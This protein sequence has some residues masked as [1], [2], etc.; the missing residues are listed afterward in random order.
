VSSGQVAQS[1]GSLIKR[2]NEW[3][4]AFFENGAIPAVLLTS[5][6]AV[7]LAE[8]ERI[9]G[10]W[11]KVLQGV[12]R[13][14]GTIVME[15]GL[16]PTV[17]GQNVVDLAMPELEKA[18]KEQILAAYDLPPG[19]AEPRMGLSDRRSLMESLWVNHLIPSTETWIEPVFNKQL[20]NALGLRLSFRYK[21]LEVMQRTELEKSES[22]VFLVQVIKG[23]FEDG[24]ASW[25]EY[26]SWVE[27]LGAWSNMP[28]LD[29]N[30]QYEE[31]ETPPQLQP[32]TGQEPPDEDDEGTDEN[33]PATAEERI[34]SR[35]PKA[36]GSERPKV[37]APPRWG[38]YRIGPT[39]SSQS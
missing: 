34:E 30:F 21:E 1:P 19:M 14:F 17:I 38:Q 35:L 7:P 9:Q 2:V 39:N 6:S 12:Q 26:R 11:N 16:T 28:P 5:E 36:T 22:S 29:P 4:T 18:K 37:A 23:A 27:Q 10:L 24:V 15:R 33:E 32:F 31:P 20:F 3:G 25:E 8:K 13:A